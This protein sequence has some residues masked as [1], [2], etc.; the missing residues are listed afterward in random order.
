MWFSLSI[1][2]LIEV[3]WLY[4][5]LVWEFYFV[6]FSIYPNF[7][8]FENK[9]LLEILFASI[10]IFGVEFFKSG[11]FFR[12]EALW[13]VCIGL[14]FYE[15]IASRRDWWCLADSWILVVCAAE[16]KYL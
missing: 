8:S 9:T 16:L 13:F 14:L 4:F 7:S 3:F 2:F 5:I 10:F 1:E 6:F 11:D 12:Y 15:N